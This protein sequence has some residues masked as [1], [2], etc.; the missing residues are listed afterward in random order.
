MRE[1]YYIGWPAGTRDRT[2]NCWFQRGAGQSGD[3]Y[4][5]PKAGIGSSPRFAAARAAG[6]LLLDLLQGGPGGILENH[7]RVDTGMVGQ[8]VLALVV[9]PGMAVQAAQLH[10]LAGG[11]IAECFHVALGLAVIGRRRVIDLLAPFVALF[12]DLVD[13]IADL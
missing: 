12:D 11:R 7:V 2:G 9:D 5:I 6:N 1:P 4:P 10:G 8:Q 13:V 3:S